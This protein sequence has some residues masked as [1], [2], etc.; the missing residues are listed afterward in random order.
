MDSRGKKHPWVFSKFLLLAPEP[1]WYS[2]ATSKAGAVG[3]AVL[4]LWDLPSR[5]STGRIISLS[6]G[7]EQRGLPSAHLL[8][9]QT[10]GKLIACHFPLLFQVCLRLTNGFQMLLKT[11]SIE[12]EGE[13]GRWEEIAWTLFILGSQDQSKAQMCIVWIKVWVWVHCKHLPLQ[14]SEFRPLPHNSEFWV[15]LLQLGSWQ[16]IIRS[17]I[18]CH[19]CRKLILNGFATEVSYWKLGPSM[20]FGSG[21]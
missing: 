3:T 18:R 14:Y 4:Q 12:K 9:S 13:A 7:C 6:C 16:S 15:E 5:A 2:T 19:V 21:E 17:I 8:I 20:I 11:I 10:E 1:L